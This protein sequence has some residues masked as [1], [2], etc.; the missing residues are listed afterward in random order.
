LN[1]SLAAAQLDF[2]GAGKLKIANV[3][4]SYDFGTIKPALI[5]A[6]EKR[7]GG[8]S[9][10]AIQI[11]ATAN[12]G[13]HQVRASIGDYRTSGGAADANWRKLGWA[14]LQPL[15][16]TMLYVSAGF[17]SNSDGANRAVSAQ[18]MAVPVNTW[19]T[20]PPATNRRAALF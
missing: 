16:R 11:G 9:V 13:V 19:A 8:P 18:G 14:M 12:F 15:Q 2:S 4:A 17:V 20:P 6:Q 10:R 3:G 1:L 5:W 7:D